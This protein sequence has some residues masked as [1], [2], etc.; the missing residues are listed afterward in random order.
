MLEKAAAKGYIP[1]SKEWLSASWQ[2]FPSTRQLSEETLQVLMK[3]LKRLGK[4]ISSYPPSTIPHRNL[5]HILGARGKIV[6]E[7]RNIDW[8]IAEA[9]AFG[10]LA[11]EKIH[12]NEQQY[13][14]L[15]DLGSNQSQFVCRRVLSLSGKRNLVTS[16]TMRSASSINSSPLGNGSG[17]GALALSCACPAGMMVKA[18]NTRAEG[19]SDS[20]NFAMTIPISSLRRRRLKDSIKIATCKLCIQ[21]HRLIIF[22]FSVADSPQ[23]PQTTHSFLFEITSAPSRRSCTAFGDSRRHS[24]PTLYF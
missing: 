10:S 20:S 1:T 13:I 23:L 15:N 21:R 3:T 17:C 16:Q 9:L 22:M 14:P 2:G 18:L 4:A 7:G 19:L 8:S 11:L 6:E 5:P 12:R 24:L